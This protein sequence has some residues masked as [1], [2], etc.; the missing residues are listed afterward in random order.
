MAQSNSRHQLVSTFPEPEIFTLDCPTQQILNL[1]SNK[2][3]VI[4]L[5][6]LVHR[7]KRYNEILH[8]IEGISAKVLTQALRKLEKY[9]LIEHQ[10]EAE[11]QQY[12]LT[13]LG[14]SLIEPLLTLAHWSRANYDKI[15]IASL[16]AK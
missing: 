8:Q 5:Y 9:R 1:I 13:A 3:I 7:P 12:R 16:T 14:E 15:K 2:W 6:C 4:I 11:N 10:I